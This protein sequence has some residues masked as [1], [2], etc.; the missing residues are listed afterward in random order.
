MGGFEVDLVSRVLTR[1]WNQV[2]GACK[3][4]DKITKA[5]LTTLQLSIIVHTYLNARCAEGAYQT[6]RESRMLVTAPQVRASTLVELIAVS[7]TPEC[8]FKVTPYR[9]KKL[10]IKQVRRTVEQNRTDQFFLDIVVRWR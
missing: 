9:T 6:A 1:A 3:S 2:E 5:V 10:V 7:D 8:E 4:S